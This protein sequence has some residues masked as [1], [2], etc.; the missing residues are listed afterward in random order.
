MLEQYLKSYNC[1]T[2]LFDWLFWGNTLLQP[3]WVTLCRL[4]GKGRKAIEETVEEMK[5]MDREESG[6]GIKVKKQKK[7]DRAVDGTPSQIPMLLAEIALVTHSKVLSN[8]AKFYLSVILFIIPFNLIC[9]MTIL[10]ET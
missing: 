10:W 8:Q 5:E 9:H 1:T 3:L 4:P 2:I 6:T 7:L